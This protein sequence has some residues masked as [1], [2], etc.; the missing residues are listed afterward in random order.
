MKNIRRYE[1]IVLAIS[2][3]AK[4]E[5]RT[6]KE[7]NSS[8]HEDNHIIDDISLLMARIENHVTNIS[9]HPF[10][11]ENMLDAY[12]VIV[13]IYMERVEQKLKAGKNNGKNG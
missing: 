3:I 11:V 4:Y 8:P 2:I 6:C 1:S 12:S 9:D 7:H 13:G 5:T 10:D